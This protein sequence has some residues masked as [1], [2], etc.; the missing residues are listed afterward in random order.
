HQDLEQSRRWWSESL[1]GFERPTL[2]PSDRPFL[3]E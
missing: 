1:R 2:V 3:R